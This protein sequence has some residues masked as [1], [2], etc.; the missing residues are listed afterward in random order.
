MT[1][2]PAYQSRPIRRRRTRAEVERLDDALFGIIKKHQ[3]VSPRQGFYLA[4][5]AGLVPKVETYAGYGVV[6]R[7][8]LIMRRSGR[9]PYEWIEDESRFVM[10]PNLS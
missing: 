6:Q 1:S 2:I 7:R 8:I 5:G 9:M 4:V 3:P 10:G